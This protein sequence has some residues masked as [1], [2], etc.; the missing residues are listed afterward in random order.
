MRIG[1]K[2]IKGMLKN[3]QKFKQ[4][5]LG[6]EPA[7]NNDSKSKEYKEWKKGITKK[8]ENRDREYDAEE[9]IQRQ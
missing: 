4:Q 3:H 6:E 7:P 9:T 5:L 2:S 8:W 1:H